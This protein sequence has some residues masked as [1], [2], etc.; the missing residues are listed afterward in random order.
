[1]G[2]D[3]QKPEITPA[4]QTSA[5]DLTAIVAGL[6]HSREVTHK[7]R[8]QGHVREL[9]SREALMKIRDGLLAVLFP[10]H[11]GCPDLTDET[12]DYFV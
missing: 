1:M 2:I 5:S 10:S 6:R 9:P 4:A 11:Y 3:D 8:Y 12:I 7:I